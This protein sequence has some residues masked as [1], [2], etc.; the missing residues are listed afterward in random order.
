MYKYLGCISFAVFFVIGCKTSPKLETVEATDNAGYTER[1][2]RRKSDFA[3]EGLYVKIDPQGNKVEEAQFSSDTLHGFRIL[4]Y[5]NGD[6]QIVESYQ[7][8]GFE[9]D[10][11]VYYPG[12]QLKML[13][14]YEDNVMTGKWK[15]YY[16]NGGLKEV[17]TF[18][19]NQENG[20][21]V[22]YHPNGNLKAEGTYLNGDYEQGELKLY[23]ENGKHIK[24]MMCEKG[25]C[26]TTWEAEKS[27]Q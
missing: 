2:S 13:G 19:N 26:R 18:K 5:E 6:T 9:G 8:G 17:V 25:V 20:P 11:K 1:Y 10:Y 12:G 24:T 27:D 14:K 22:E 15:I 16:E 3:K 4:Y 23:D 7:M 21:F